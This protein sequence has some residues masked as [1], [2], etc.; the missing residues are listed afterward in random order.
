VLKLSSR[1]PSI[2]SYSQSK[3]M[4]VDYQKLKVSHEPCQPSFESIY[5]IRRIDSYFI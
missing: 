5:A 4:Y 1:R 2:Y 3:N